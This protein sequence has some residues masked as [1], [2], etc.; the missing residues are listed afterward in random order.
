[1]DKAD[2]YWDFICMT[3]GY[4]GTHWRNKRKCPA[5]GESLTR[6]FE[7]RDD[8]PVSNEAVKPVTPNDEPTTAVIGE[9][10]PITQCAHPKCN[11][12]KG[13]KLCETGCGEYYCFKHFEGRHQCRQ[14]VDPLRHR[15]SEIAA[16]IREVKLL[17]KQGLE[18]SK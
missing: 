13:L 15:L 5:C 4:N 2:G 10:T 16:E 7:N 11:E 1:M 12:T 18:R 6:V 9:P 14:C 3:C 17:I 8:G